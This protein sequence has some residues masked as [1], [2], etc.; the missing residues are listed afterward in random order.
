MLDWLRPAPSLPLPPETVRW[1]DARWEWLTGQ[2]GEPFVRGRPVV[3]P[4]PEFFPDP[5]SGEADEVRA[6]LDRVCHYM[7][8]DPSSVVLHFYSEQDSYGDR[9]A[10]LYVEGNGVYHVYVEISNLGDPLALVATMAHELGHVLLLGHR[11]ID[12]E[13]SDHEPLTDL[14]TVFFGM[15][16]FTANSVVRD[17]T[18]RMGNYSTWSIS[19]LGYLTMPMFGYALARLAW[20]R[21]EPDAAWSKELRPDVRS[22][23]RQSIR[24]FEANG[25]V[26]Q[27]PLP[28]IEKTAEDTEPAEVEDIPSASAALCRHCREPF[29][30]DHVQDASPADLPRDRQGILRGICPACMVTL[31]N[32]TKPLDTSGDIEEIL[33]TPLAWGLQAVKWFWI[34]FAALCGLILIRTIVVG[35][36]G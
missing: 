17:R 31:L 6:M 5:Y 22:A 18:E 27:P 28:E 13:E 29:E 2:F 8:V 20:A 16:L 1:I 9:T 3:L 12:P 30:W 35:I 26:S 4:T 7:T 36:F 14:L 25:L 19:R 33:P 10:G 21:E 24:F 23:F 11:R 15:G 32:E 34:L